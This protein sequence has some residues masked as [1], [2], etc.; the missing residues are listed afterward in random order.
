L[1]PEYEIGRVLDCRLL[2]HNLNDT[3]LVRTDR[4]PFILRVYQAQH[5][6]WRSRRSE[7]E[8]R[9]ELDL[10]VHL[11][12]KAVPVSVPIP[13]KGGQYLTALEAPEGLR[14][15]A[16]MS[17]AAGL[18]LSAA[19]QTT[20]TSYLYGK[21]VAAIHAASDDFSSPSIR[22]PLD[23]AY[24][25]DEPLRILEPLLAHRQDD[26]SYLLRSAAWLGNRIA[27]L[28]I[29]PCHGDT[30][31]GNAHITPEGTITF[32]DFENCGVGWRAYDVG[33]FYWGAA[34]GEAR[35][36][37]TEEQSGRRG[38]AFLEGYLASRTLA[39]NDLQLIP[40]MAAIRQFWYL[41]LTAGNWQN[42]SLNDADDSRLDKE[43]R[44]L[45][46][47]VSRMS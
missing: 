9:Y 3:Y 47:L 13:K 40:A 8:V 5:S 19:N 30:N 44:F 12:Q 14:C 33:T 31:G 43:I 42:W 34:M 37:W 6:I 41:G 29:G 23:F 36:G 21:A 2:A 4:D 39:D 20:E 15:A 25:V 16:L 26:W 38:R 10:L 17:Y 27:G 22:S 11:A 1:L 18:P 46:T 32:F 24:L 35:L 28:E 7:P 45:R